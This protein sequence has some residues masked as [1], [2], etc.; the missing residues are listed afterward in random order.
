[1][2]PQHS[3]LNATFSVPQHRVEYCL[4]TD[5][6]YLYVNGQLSFSAGYLA[7]SLLKYHPYMT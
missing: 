5:A 4:P 1:M 6:M 2:T 3:L 7:L